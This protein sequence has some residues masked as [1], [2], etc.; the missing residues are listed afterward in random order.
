LNSTFGLNFILC[1]NNK[2]IPLGMQS[3]ENFVS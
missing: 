3:Y 2:T 1:L